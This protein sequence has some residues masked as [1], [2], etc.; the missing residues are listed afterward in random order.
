MPYSLKADRWRGT[1]PSSPEPTLNNV[2]RGQLFPVSPFSSEFWRAEVDTTS[3]AL[4]MNAYYLMAGYMNTV[5]FAATFVWCGY[6]SG[7]TTQLAIAVAR[8]WEGERKHFLL[9]DRQALTSLL[10]FIIGALVARFGG[11]LM[12]ARSRGWFILGTFLQA[13]LTM[14]AAIS[15]WQ[16]GQGYPGISDDRFTTGPAWNDEVSF[17][18]LV[19][20]S[21]SMGMQGL[22]SLRLKTNSGATLPLTTTWCELMGVDALFSFTRLD[23]PRDQRVYGIGSVFLGGLAARGIAFKL[24]SPGV[25]AV[26]VGLRVLISLSWCLVPNTPEPEDVKEQQEAE[27]R[28]GLEQG[29]YQASTPSGSSQV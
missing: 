24:G 22:M 23:T 6:Q 17:L 15:I 26:G 19:F 20:M 13:L 14:A 11:N 29:Q 2:R 10:S 7:N 27:K 16:S 4:Q 21:A 1:S 9:A 18:C 8:L 25:L 3:C 12:G 28:P 5:S